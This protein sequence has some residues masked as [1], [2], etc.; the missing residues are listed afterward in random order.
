MSFARILLFAATVFV[1]P[2]GLAASAAEKAPTATS[3]REQ[4]LAFYDE[5]SRKVEADKIEGMTSAQRDAFREIATQIRGELAKVA[6][7]DELDPGARSSLLDSHAK[8]VD[9]LDEIEDNRL[10]CTRV[11]PVGSNMSRRECRTVAQIRA[12]REAAKSLMQR[13]GSCDRSIRNCQ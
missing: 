7:I 3:T 2:S 11:K 12:E 1:A 4:F 13:G 8:V 9:L 10:V 6:S 5:V